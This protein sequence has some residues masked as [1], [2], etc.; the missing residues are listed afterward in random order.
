MSKLKPEDFIQK[1]LDGELAEQAR[2]VVLSG[3]AMVDESERGFID[4]NPSQRCDD[5]WIRLP[6]SLIQNIEPLGTVSCRDHK[7][8]RVR[9]ALKRPES[10]ESAIFYD[11]LS[12]TRETSSAFPS[13]PGDE[14][15]YG[16]EQISGPAT[17]VL[18]RCDR[19][20]RTSSGIACGQ[21]RGALYLA[22][23][24]AARN[25]GCEDD[26]IFSTTFVDAWHIRR[27]ICGDGPTRPDH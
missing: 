3:L 20:G 11:L 23:E 1:S 17:K 16:I 10:A 4:F 24:R 21:D 2:T 12:L 19:T 13:L 27:P 7:H 14:E 22:W 25:A 18:V 9:V 15:N 26:S 6:V 8:E 5:E